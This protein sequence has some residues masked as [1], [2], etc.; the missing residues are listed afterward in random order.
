MCSKKNKKGQTMMEYIILVAL[1]AVASIPIIRT[2]G[3]V[4]RSNILESAD[5]LVSGSKFSGDGE[6]MVDKASKKVKRTMSNFHDTFA[7]D[8]DGNSTGK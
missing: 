4:F 5:S 6:D 2:L 1:L 7:P 8:T 3:N